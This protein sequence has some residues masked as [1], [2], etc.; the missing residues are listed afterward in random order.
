MALTLTIENETSLPDGGPL[1]VTVSGKRGIDFG[2]DKHLDWT[3]P[4]PSRAISSKHCEVRYQ[5]GGYWLYDVST[6]GTFLEGADGRL[7][8]PHRLRN[9]ERLVIGHYIVGVKVDAEPQAEVPQARA[10]QPATYQDLWNASDDAAPAIDASQLRTPRERPAAVNPDFLDWA[11]DIP[12]AF[13]SLA[14]VEPSRPAA[15][16]PVAPSDPFAPLPEL[17]RPQSRNASPAAPNDMDW[18]EGVPHQAEPVPEAPP[19]IPTPR[20]PV[21]VSSEPSGPW[22]AQSPEAPAARDPA[23]RDP[24]ARDSVFDE[25]PSAAAEPQEVTQREPTPAKEAAPPPESFVPPPEPFAPPP[26]PAPAMGH[27]DAALPADFIRLLARGAGIPEEVFARKQPEQLAE[28]LGML[29]R[30]VTENTRQ[31]LQARLQAK[32][33][34]RSTSQTMVQ[35]LDNNPLKFSPTTEDALRIMFGPPTQSYLDARRTFEK[36]FDD[37]KK[38]QIRTFSAMQQALTML[39][40]DLDPVAIDQSTDTDRGIAALVTSR[41][42]RL[43][44]AYVTRWQAKTRKYEGGLLDV[45]MDYF[46]DSY[47]GT[48]EIR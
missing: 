40:E 21:W 37:L 33:L 12:D 25:P 35:A 43:W 22:S 3:L 10:V 27:A 24:I 19:P 20:R 4:D 34:A 13:N 15:P 5:D 11:A 41:K 18:A 9:G 2:R 31:L 32:R 26:T 8:G 16:S 14:P 1:S 48:N 28:E 17:T 7:K 39:V 23:A 45:F 6:N 36:S 42:A 38:H 44:D 47:D 46:A 30:V 29:L